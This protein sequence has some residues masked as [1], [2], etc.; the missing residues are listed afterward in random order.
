MNELVLQNPIFRMLSEE[1][2][3]ELLSH[4]KLKTYHPDEIMIHEGDFNH[5][6]Y[7]LAHGTVHVV[8]NDEIVAG[9]GAGDVVGEISALGMSTPVADV[10]AVDEVR[11]IA[12]PIELITDLGLKYPEF[13]EQLR[14]ISSVRIYEYS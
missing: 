12:F 2:L 3:L 7:L 6:L 11:A 8:A 4:S 1:A 14:A 13:A 10:I 9:L 5:F